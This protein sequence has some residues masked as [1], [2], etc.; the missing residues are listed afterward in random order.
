MYSPQYNREVLEKVHETS[1]TLSRIARIPVVETDEEAKNFMDGIS[2]ISKMA[3]DEL[4]KLEGLSLEELATSKQTEP[5]KTAVLCL[6]KSLKMA[7]DATAGRAHDNEIVRDFSKRKDWGAGFSNFERAV[8]TVD[9]ISSM[10]QTAG[11]DASYML[12][13]RSVD[14]SGREEMATRDILG[15]A[16]FYELLRSEKAILTPMGN[17]KG[18]TVG[19]RRFGGGFEYPTYGT[20]I[21]A[22]SVNDM[23][24]AL[25]VASMRTKAAAAYKEIFRHGSGRLNYGYTAWP[26]AG[27]DA[28]TEEKTMGAAYGAIHTLNEAARQMIE[29]AIQVS[30]GTKK[31]EKG[32]T[33]AALPVT[34]STPVLVYYNHTHNAILS[35]IQRLILGPNGLNPT[36]NYNFV[37]VPTHLA[38]VSAG[39]SVTDETERDDYGL[40]G[41]VKEAEALQKAAVRLVIPGFRNLHGTFQGL[42]FNNQTEVLKESVTVAAFERY[43]FITDNRQTARVQIQA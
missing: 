5:V 10:M 16:R 9:E 31:G 12:A 37:F 38:P 26:Y 3:P 34:A 23:L 40:F 17:E 13:Y 1:A 43:T 22:V 30:S 41:K 21:S 14:A 29:A 19:F 25:R 27:T 42:S 4:R 7:S 33:E 18:D 8:V 36:L 24:A 20:D 39:W 2:E 35:L 28:T 32:K 6:S 15:E 11:I